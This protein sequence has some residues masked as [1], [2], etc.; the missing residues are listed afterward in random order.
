MKEILEEI[1]NDLK[2]YKFIILLGILGAATFLRF[3]Y[4]FF[5]GSWVDE[6]HHARV[7]YEIANHPWKY[8]VTEEW[9]G[10]LTKY[11]PVFAY[12]GALST[13][14]FGK[15]EFAI[16]IVSP[17]VSIVGI[18]LMYVFGREIEN[19][20]IGLIAAALLT[21]NPIFWYLSERILIGATLTT[22]YIAT[23]LALFYGLEN[24]EYS[25]YV[26]W[27]LGPLVGL[28]IMTKQPA[29]AMGLI[30]PIYYIYKRWDDIQEVYR[31]KKLGIVR[32]HFQDTGI[33][34]GLGIL[35]LLPWMLRNMQVC[36]FPLCGLMKALRFATQSG[37]ANAAIASVQSSF[38]FLATLPQT[39]TLP[40]TILL[41]LRVGYYI[42]ERYE[43][44]PDYLVKAG[45]TTA[46]LTG[47]AFFFKMELFA[48]AAIS[49]VALYATT[50]SEKLMWLWA[51]IGIG[52]M[53]IPGVKVPRY[54][55]FAIPALIL[56]GTISLY[57]ITSW[58]SQ[59]ADSKYV[60]AGSLAV[61]ALIPILFMS[62][63]AGLQNVN[64]GGYSELEPAGKWVGENTP[65]DAVIA[66]S[67]SRQI[68]WYAYPRV[69]Y[70]PPNNKSN[71]SNW[72]Q[73][74]N[75]T[76]MVIDTYERAQPQWTQTD[77]A[78]YRIPNEIK[79][80][81]RQGKIS[82]QE[83]QQMFKQNPEYLVP[84]KNFGKERMPL[85]KQKQ[86]AVIVYRINKTALNQ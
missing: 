23:M 31:E 77:I 21:V 66:S 48:M 22:I 50:D 11:P 44:N 34:I 68:M 60:N 73:E 46:L 55:V 9:R 12:L 20:D 14:F 56:V 71:F 51:G 7:A 61:L 62:Y 4:A 24:R 27:A 58:L 49:S 19:R 45:L 5:E 59:M 69:S 41:A 47:I 35:F 33:A 70:M 40:I 8:A 85:T 83:I 75:V 63:T 65:E 57:N 13:W 37:Q 39:V 6:G 10:A 64:I 2:D 32:S 18:G 17:V 38:Y 16:R 28:A 79:I 25:K 84:V 53:S 86:P 76:H 78:P 82:T 54:I 30:I 15:S 74:R 43:A 36:G 81:A 3:K 42:L 52:F 67:S 80:Q 72:A 1:Q 29:F 26:I